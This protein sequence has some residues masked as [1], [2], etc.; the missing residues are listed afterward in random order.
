MPLRK[1]RQ[2]GGQETG[3]EG[4]QPLHRVVQWFK[5]MTTNE[6]IKKV[7]NNGWQPFKEKMWQRNYYEHIIRNEYELNR[8]REYIINNPLKWELDFENPNRIKQYVDFTAYMEEK[9]S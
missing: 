1:I 7:K 4:E 5:T 6:Y 2:E 8:I 3:Q 9:L